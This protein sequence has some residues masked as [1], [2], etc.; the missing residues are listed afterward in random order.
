MRIQVLLLKLVV[1]LGLVG[2]FSVYGEELSSVQKD[3]IRDLEVAK[4][5]IMLKYAPAEWKE[6]LFGWSL[7]SAYA[8][9]KR[10]IVEESPKTS[11]EYQKIFKEFLGSTRDYHV[12]PI[13][14]STASS[15]FP[16]SVRRVK[17]RYFVTAFPVDFVLDSEDPFLS[18]QEGL[19]PDFNK[20]LKQFKIGDELIAFD[21][22]PIQTYIAKLIKENLN[23]DDSATGYALACRNLFSRS[24][25]FGHDVPKGTFKLTMQ[26][27]GES[28]T[29][30]CTLPWI[31]SPE[32]IIE[33]ILRSQVPVRVPKIAI[34]QK[35]KNQ[36]VLHTFMDKD[37][38][39]ELAKELTIDQKQFNLV[40][41]SGQSKEKTNDSREKGLLPALG[42]VIWQTPK[43]FDVYAYIYKNSREIPI[44]YLYIP[45]FS[46]PQE[47]FDE[48]I[49]QLIAVLK[50]FNK[51]TQALVIDITNNN[52]GNMMY[53]YAVLSLLSEK[54]LD[55]Y[56]N[57]EILVQ[58]DVYNVALMYKDL[59]KM[60]ISIMDQNTSTLSGYPFNAKTLTQLIDYSEIIMKTWARGDRIT[61]PIYIFGIDKIVPHTEVTYKKPIVVLTNETCFSCADFFP[62]ILQDNHRAVI[63]GTT[64][65]GAGGYV[66]RHDQLSRFGLSGYSLTASI[67]YR[68]D[69]NVIENRGVIPDFPYEITIEDAQRNYAGYIKYLNKKIIDI[70]QKK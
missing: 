48:L 51:K 42:Q 35:K 68:L 43:D 41:A 33:G 52:G 26:H 18:F 61:N 17:D 38:S 11:K 21:G 53:M 65:A 22:I 67:A 5:S 7:E 62:A 69:G 27:P 66:R 57:K 3:M 54:P 4:Y 60:D 20:C 15:M 50:I 28:K 32:W 29:W 2:S 13:Y 59:E 31:H 44:G 23:R 37:F 55:L 10:R 8:K 30:T 16:L 39:V 64:T 49:E 56:L 19:Y 40:T 24:G 58:E 46:Y 63:F 47:H 25:R 45:S 70:L 12:A 9:A 14:Y 6:V 36:D 1:F 34:E